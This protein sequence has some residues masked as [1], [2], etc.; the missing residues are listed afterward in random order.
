VDYLGKEELLYL[1]PDELRRGTSTGSWNGRASAGC[2]A[3]QRSQVA[4][5]IA[6]STTRNMG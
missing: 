1:G 4:N 6:G 3:R 2:G 5:Q